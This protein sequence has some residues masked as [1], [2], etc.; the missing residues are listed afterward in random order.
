MPAARIASSAV[1]TARKWYVFGSG[2]PRVV[3]AVS[4]LTIVR[5]VLEST[6]AIGPNAVAG[7]L[8]RSAVR[9]MKWTSPANANV[10]SVAGGDAGAE[11]A[12]SAAADAALGVAAAAPCRWPPSQPASASSATSPIVRPNLRS[13]APAYEPAALTAAPDFVVPA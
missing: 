4:R 8:S 2:V 6:D 3:I 11:V 10:I 5:S 12:G 13:I 1:G 7:F 9:S